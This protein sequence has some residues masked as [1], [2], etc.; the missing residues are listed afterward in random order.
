MRAKTFESTSTVLCMLEGGFTIVESTM[1]D[2]GRD[3]VSC[4]TCAT[5]SSSAMQAQFTA[6]VENALDR[7]VRAYLS[8]GPH[9]TPTSRSSCSCRA[10]GDARGRRARA[11]TPEEQSET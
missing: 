2:I 3:A 5:T 7:R 4:A 6:V 10:A 8:Q 11:E 9:T 1:I